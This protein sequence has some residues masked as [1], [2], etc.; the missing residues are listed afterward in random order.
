MVR[1]AKKSESYGGVKIGDCTE[2]RL[3]FADDFALLDS[4]QNG[5]QQALDRFSNACSVAGMKISTIKTENMCLF[6]QPKQ[7]SLL[8]DGVPIKQSEKFKYL[9]V[10]FMIDGRQNSELDIRIGKTSAVIRQVHRS[11]VLKRELCTRAR[12]SIFRSVYVPILT[13]GRECWIVNEKVRSRV[14][15]AE[16]GFL[17]RI[18]GL[19]LLDKVKSADIRES[20]NIELLLL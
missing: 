15:A 7:C 17:L 5:L 13:Y 14:Q 6:R 1:I 3:L 2:Q 12:L 18:S 19:T 4:T 11:V 20:V 16:M 9:G 10:S 8:I